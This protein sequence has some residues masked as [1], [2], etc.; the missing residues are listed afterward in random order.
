MRPFESDTED[1]LFEQSEADPD[2]LTEAI[3]RVVDQAACGQISGLSVVRLGD[4]VVL[5]GHSRTYHASQLARQAVLD[6][7]GDSARLVDLI[8]IL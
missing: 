7:L 4:T 1:A 6:L 8:L 3:E 5:N 2:G